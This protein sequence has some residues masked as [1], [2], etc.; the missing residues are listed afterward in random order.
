[1]QSSF[2][3]SFGGYTNQLEESRLRW[4]FDSRYGAWRSPGIPSRAAMPYTSGMDPDPSESD[5]GT[6]QLSKA[7]GRRIAALRGA[8]KSADLAKR[9]EMTPSYLSRVETGRTVVSVRNAARIALGLG[10][11][12]SEL[13]EGVALDPGSLGSREYKAVRTPG[14]PR[15]A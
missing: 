14:R 2:F 9:I 5:A 13:F 10:V 12:L 8:E 4:A 11:T 3:L 6:D 15:K 7:I 1:V